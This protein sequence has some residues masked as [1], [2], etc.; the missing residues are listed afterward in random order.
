MPDIDLVLISHDHYD[1]LDYDSI[2]KIKVKAK[3]FYVALGVKGILVSWG[4]AR[5]ITE[6]DW[7]QRSFK[8]YKITFTPTRHFSGRVLTDRAKS[9][10]GG[11]V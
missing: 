3:Q 10:W 9:L 8:G 2:L 6:F 11:F 5:L 7:W 1:H 4:I